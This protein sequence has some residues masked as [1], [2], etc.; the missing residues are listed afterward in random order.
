MAN[1]ESF[2]KRQEVEARIGI[3]GLAVGVLGWATGIG[4]FSTVGWTAAAVGGG[5]YVGDR[6]INGR[7][8]S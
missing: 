7:K 6:V 3:G 4:I 2:R 5:A 8:Q 1:T